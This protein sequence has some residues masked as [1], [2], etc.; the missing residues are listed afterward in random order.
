MRIVL[1][2]GSGFLG[3]VL[4]DPF[5]DQRVA[6]SVLTRRSAEAQR[7]NHIL[8]DGRTPGAWE[9]TLDGADVL[10]NLCGKSV[11]CRYHDA[12]KRAI[13]ASR[14]DSTRLLG[15]A[16]ARCD[17]PPRLW[18]NASSATIYRHAEDRGMDEETGELGV[19]FSV[20]VCRRWEQTFF[21]AAIPGNVRRCALRTGIVLGRG[22]GALT[23]LRKLVRAGLGG[24]LGNGRQYFTWLHEA[25]FAGI[26]EH[27]MHQ[28]SLSGVVNVCAPTPM[29]N[30]DFMAALR[31][32]Y[33]MPIGLSSPTW[34]LE[35]GAFI[36]RTE[37][38]LIL[39]SR[40][41]VPRRLLE[42]GYAFRYPTL[43]KALAELAGPPA[44]GQHV[45]GNLP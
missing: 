31:R 22:G 11:D 23:V 33:G 25:D 28:D 32:A 45:R 19:G 4:Q 15:E 41:V 26:V 10:L 2:G 13:Y 34:M 5:R 16:V 20:D 21:D 24:T 18:I 12:N 27:I 38:E 30:R 9:Q 8:W 40:R 1:A 42:S 37:T 6:V 7:P 39:K 43:E 29:P 17:Q 14:L 3:K 44:R 35:L 36:I